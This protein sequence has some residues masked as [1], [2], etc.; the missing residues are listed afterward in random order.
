MMH[1]ARC[2]NKVSR[3]C[4]R[5]EGHGNC[6]KPAPKGAT[7]RS[8]DPAAPAGVGALVG[9]RPVICMP[10]I[11]LCPSGTWARPPG[12]DRVAMGPVLSPRLDAARV[13]AAFTP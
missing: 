12:I 1:N 9:R 7:E 3:W 8:L 11:N 2:V 10:A 5:P 4:H 6:R 13:L